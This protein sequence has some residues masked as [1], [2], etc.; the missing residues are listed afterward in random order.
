MSDTLI[1]TSYHPSWEQLAAMTCKT[2][3]DYAK[4]HGY[5][6]M[7]DCSDLQDVVRGQG[8]RIGIRGF[9]KFDLML[10]YMNVRPDYKYIVWID[11][12]ALVTNQAI[13]IEEKRSPGITIGYDHNG[14][15]STVWI[16]HATPLVRDYLWA[17]NNTGRAFFLAHD[18]H[19]M[20]SMRYF[21][22]TPPYRDLL[23][24]RSVK[25]MC[26][27]LAPEYEPH[28]PR[29]VSDKYAWE[30]GDWILH[31]SALPLQRRI[32]RARE[33]GERLKLL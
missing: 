28:L 23:E 15:H 27:I 33:I 20:E 8:H 14:I 16:A 10:H 18:W 12:D 21:S 1:I 31:L 7:A 13:P 2:H 26:P 4:R 6:Y 19:E 25:E 9:I 24:Y 32:E 30:E 11:A 29:W 3:Y 5:D 22:Q 17:C